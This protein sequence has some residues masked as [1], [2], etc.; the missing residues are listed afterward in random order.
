MI[1]G[2]FFYSYCQDTPVPVPVTTGTM[3]LK[4]SI[5][6][7]S[8]HLSCMQWNFVRRRQSGAMRLP[9]LKLICVAVQTHALLGPTPRRVAVQSPSL[10]RPTHMRAG[11]VSACDIPVGYRRARFAALFPV[12]TMLAAAIGVSRPAACARTFG[13]P[14]AFQRGLGLLMALAPAPR[15]HSTWDERPL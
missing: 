15:G 11:V 1:F 2:V 6:S 9:I 7:S 3:L 10:Q 14:L 12:W 5:K 8:L 13:S 4:S